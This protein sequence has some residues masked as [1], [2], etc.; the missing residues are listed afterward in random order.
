MRAKQNT[1]RL[2]QETLFQGNCYKKQVIW[3]N[4]WIQWYWNMKTVHMET[5]LDLLEMCL[6]STASDASTKPHLG[7]VRSP[8]ASR[9]CRWCRGAHPREGAPAPPP[10]GPPAPRPHWWR[11]EWGWEGQLCCGVSAG[12]GTRPP[13]ALCPSQ[14]VLSGRKRAEKKF[15][16]VILTF[17]G[18]PH[19]CSSNLN[20]L[21]E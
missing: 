2:F 12:C 1:Q 10:P 19:C 9:Q 4:T 16:L 17:A 6:A 15:D 18:Q 3:C 7:C 11:P 13:A 5:K 8:P 21:P 14:N 20:N